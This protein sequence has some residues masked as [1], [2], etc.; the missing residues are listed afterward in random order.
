MIKKTE[1]LF[2]VCLGFYLVGVS[3]FIFWENCQEEKE[4]ISTID[5]D[6]VLA[7]SALKYLLPP[8]FHDR[9]VDAESISFEE[10][11]RNREAVSGFASES[12]IKWIYTLAEKQGKFYFSAP[13]VS[14]EEAR[15]RKRWYWYPYDDIPPEFV[16]AI[17]ERKTAFVEYADQWGSFRSIAVPLVSPGG[18]PYLACADYEIT[19]I[20]GKLIKKLHAQIESDSPVFSGCDHPDYRDFL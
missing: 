15:E 12:D 3:G 9:A 16:A 17:R 8:D 14:E 18:N 20:Q 5:K 7:T 1:G 11:M 2:I 6:L 13:T 4:L 19:F 10:E